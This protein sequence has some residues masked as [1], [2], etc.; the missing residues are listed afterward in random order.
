MRHLALLLAAGLVIS[1]GVAGPPVAPETIGVAPTIQR[2]K[3]EHQHEALEAERREKAAAEQEI[4]PD[5]ELQ[6][7]DSELPP[8][9]PVGTR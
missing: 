1:C 4:E 6:G 7:E 9:N 5:L 8:L 3:L 2:Q